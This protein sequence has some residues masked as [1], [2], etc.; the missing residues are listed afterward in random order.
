MGFMGFTNS[1]LTLTAILL[2]ALGMWR[3]GV[4]YHDAMDQIE[5]HLGTIQN[6]MEN[7]K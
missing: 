4:V 2:F 5:P 7:L 6:T 3:A 1:I